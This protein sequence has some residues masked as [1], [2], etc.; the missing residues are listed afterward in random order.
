[1][2]LEVLSSSESRDILPIYDDPETGGVA[3]ELVAVDN[4]MTRLC[5]RFPGGKPFVVLLVGE[6]AQAEYDQAAMKASLK[7]AV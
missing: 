3:R 4:H 6:T 5:V 7:L 1:M 2:E